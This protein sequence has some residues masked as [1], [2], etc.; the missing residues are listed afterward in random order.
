MALTITETLG[1]IDAVIEFWTHRKLFLQ[2]RGL[3]NINGF[4]AELTALKEDLLT[5]NDQQ[6]ALKALLRTKTDEVKTARRMASENTS[7][8]LDACIGVLGKRTELG[9][10]AARIRSQIRR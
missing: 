2:S 3:G 6:E 9:K 8:K 10:Q 7:T 4:I 5:K 1:F